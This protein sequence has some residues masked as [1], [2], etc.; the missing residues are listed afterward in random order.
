MQMQMVMLKNQ[1]HQGVTLDATSIN[2]ASIRV[3]QSEQ[4]TVIDNTHRTVVSIHTLMETI[5]RNL[6]SIRRTTDGSTQQLHDAAVAQPL[7]QEAEPREEETK[8]IY[9]VLHLTPPAARRCCKLG[10]QWQTAASD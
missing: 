6:E 2:V 3:V 10:A 8:I 5:H 7:L 4:G 9:K 1:T